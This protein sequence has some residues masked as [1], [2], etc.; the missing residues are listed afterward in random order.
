MFVNFE[1]LFIRGSFSK[2]N[3]KA[4]LRSN[5]ELLCLESRVVP[6]TFTVL[7]TN[8]SGANSLRQAIFD[9]NATPGNDIID[10]SFGSG[11]SPNTITLATALPSIASTSS[12]GTLTITGPGATSLTI[13]ANLNN[14]SVFTISTGGNLS[15]S[16]VTVTGVRTTSVSPSGGAI[17]NSGIFSV[18]D[19]IIT[20]NQNTKN[21]NN[22]GSGGINNNSNAIL[23]IS[24]SII[25]NNQGRAG[26][27]IHNDGGTVK[28]T[29]STIKSN[30]GNTGDNRGG[31][32]YS[33]NGTLTV[34]NSTFS[35]NTIGFAGGGMAIRNGNATINN[36]T[37]SNNSGTYG[38]GVYNEGG[39][40]TISSFTLAYNSVS[41]MGGGIEN[42]GTLYIANTI[43]SNNTANNSGPQYNTNGSGTV[44]FISG[45]LASNNLVPDSSISGANTGPADLVPLAANGGNTFTIA[46]GASS[47][48]IGNGSASV[49]NA[50]PIFGLDQRGYVRSSTLPSIGAYEYNASPAPLPTITNISPSTGPLAGGTVIT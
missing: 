29:N 24:N 15:V 28:V 46:L 42:N 32:I 6:A 13:N 23:N 50:S 44:N 45:S 30:S 20:G 16:G 7:N 3:T 19:S 27:G 11:G 33:V 26:G 10:F 2:N 25:S 21:I 36:S 39:T 43:I 5:M 47:T 1:N 34:S 38:G 22:G 12:A 9:A 14:F 4:R 8:D 49:S 35:S 31:G 37:F 17:Y 18:Y 40:V 48:A 41:Q